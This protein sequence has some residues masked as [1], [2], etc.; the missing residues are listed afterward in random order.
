MRY[1][2]LDGHLH[3]KVFIE[4]L[5]FR[6]SNEITTSIKIEALLLSMKLQEALSKLETELDNQVKLSHADLSECK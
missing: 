2:N 6:T 4:F 1:K 3:L 5:V